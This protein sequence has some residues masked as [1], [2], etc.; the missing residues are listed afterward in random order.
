MQYQSI[1]RFFEYAHIDYNNA[2]DFNFTRAKKLVNAEFAMQTDGFIAIDD[3]SYSK[4][5][6]LAEMDRA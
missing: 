6:I 1:I 5:D 4:N 2:A 3:F